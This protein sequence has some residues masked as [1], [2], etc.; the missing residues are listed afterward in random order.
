MIQNYIRFEYM[1]KKCRFGDPSNI[2][3]QKTKITWNVQ[4]EQY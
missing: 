4:F 3:P 1:E 2:I